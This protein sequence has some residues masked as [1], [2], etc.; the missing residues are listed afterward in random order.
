ML[1]RL[2]LAVFISLA[3]RVQCQEFEAASIRPSPPLKTF[4]GPL[5]FGSRGGPGT[6][7][8]GRYTCNFC[9]L[10]DLISAAYDVPDYRIVSSRPL[11]EDRF[12][13]IATIA[14][15]TSREEFRLMLQ[16][17][18]ASRFELQAHTDQRLMRTNTLVVSR[19]GVRLRPHV[20]GDSAL[21]A[22]KKSSRQVGFYYNAQATMTDFARVL[23]NRLREPVVDATGL[24][25][26]YDFDLS[27]GFDDLDTQVKRLI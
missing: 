17:L 8:A 4:E 27:W 12:T 22:A 20:D 3:M 26:R 2:V 15:G 11:P 16:H 18:L 14:V 5:S 1:N 7:D 10:R 13:V 21:A 19:K 23:E 25:G 6:E 24:L 9:E